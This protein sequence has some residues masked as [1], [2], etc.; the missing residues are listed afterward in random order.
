[1]PVLSSSNRSQLSAKLEGVYP[2]NF[3]SLQGGN[4]TLMNML[5]ESL[6]Y[7]VK[8][9][10]S[11][12]LRSDRGVADIVQVGAS[13][14]GGFGFEAQYK[15]YD[16]FIEGVMQSTYTVYGTLG[17][18]A[19]IATLTLAAGTITAGVAPTG[20]DAFTNLKK[21]Q[22]FR[23]V[24]PAGATQIVKDYFAGRA[25]RVSTI[26]APTATI[27][28][29]D[30][31]TPINTAVAGTTVSAGFITSSRVENGNT[32]RSWSIEVQH[33]DI[34]QFRQ[35]LGMIPSKMDLK[36]ASGSIV[37]GNFDF[38]G[39]G[40]SLVQA[41][42]MG[43]AAAAQTYTPANATRGVFDLFENGVSINSLTFIKS[44]DITIDNTLRIQDAVSVFGAAGIASGTFNC[45]GKLEV[46]F[47]EHTIYQKM[48]NNTE[49]SLSVPILDIAGNGYVYYFPRI[50]YKS[51]KVGTGGQD[52]DNMLSMEFQALPDATVGSDTFGK[53][54]VIYRV[55]VAV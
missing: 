2:T 44:A 9:E 6:N 15:E 27:I 24:P 21:G 5:S 23:I 51:A 42:G 54:C 22:W 10:Q 19:S 7:D 55:G 49:S 36:L 40:F 16:P 8:T 41:T 13:S 52:Q 37:T 34:T 4:G 31:A 14:M 26:T 18:S 43:S 39:K 33:G 32:M 25:F 47:A 53:T 45:S 28:T 50:K 20:N 35:Y 17:V 12:Q 46:Y 38:M 30:A 3:G 48:L 1:M 11:K 29:L